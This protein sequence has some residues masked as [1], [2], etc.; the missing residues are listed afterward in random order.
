MA[1]EFAAHDVRHRGTGVKR[2]HH[3]TVGE[4]GSPSEEEPAPARFL[5][6]PQGAT[7]PARS[8][9]RP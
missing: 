7:A 8:V 9:R 1:V 6:R 4:P 5:G 2:L 3:A